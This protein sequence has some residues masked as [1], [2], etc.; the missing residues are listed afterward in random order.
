MTATR[1]ALTRER[2]LEA[3]KGLADAEGLGVVTMRRLAA[4]LGVEAMSLYHHVPSKDALLDGLIAA[5]VGEVEDAT[6]ESTGAEWRATLRARCLAAR[7]VMVRHPWAPGLLATRAT[8]P[9]S[10]VLYYE[11]VLGLLVE[12]GFSYSLAHRALHAL[13][14]L[15]LGFVQELFSPAAAGGSLDAGATEAELE[16]LVAALPHLSAMVA[17]EVHAHD[18]D[19]LGWCDSRTELEFTLDLLLDGLERRRR[20]ELS[21]G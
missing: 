1:K 7:D 19:V 3:A 11:R 20:E 17:A 5:V 4:E 18:G 2:I 12:G 13:G 8:I 21:Q 6:A 16:E 10:I 9:T 15:P 14:S